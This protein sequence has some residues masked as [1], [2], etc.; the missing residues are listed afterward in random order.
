MVKKLLAL[1]ALSCGL[2]SSIAAEEAPTP[3]PSPEPAPVVVPLVDPVVVTDLTVVDPSAPTEK[4][5]VH[6]EILSIDDLNDV[7]GIQPCVG[8]VVADE[9]YWAPSKEWVED[10]LLPA[11][12][13]FKGAMELEYGDR[14]DCDDFSKMF[15]AFANL[16]YAKMRDNK[17]ESLAV[18]QYLYETDDKV[19]TLP[20]GLEV[21]MPG[22]GHAINVLILPDKT[23][24]FVEP[25]SGE[26]VVLTENEMQHCMYVLF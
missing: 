11:W 16:Y 7:H 8:A 2:I 5:V 4:P 3:A 20:N 15:S 1:V 14:Y 22:G 19:L 17:A 26:V 6:K 21:T 18:A 23:A 25:Q 12:K 9:T 24:L 13:R 10:A